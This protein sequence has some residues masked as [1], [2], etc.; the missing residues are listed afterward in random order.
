[1]NLGYI[2]VR[3]FSHYLLRVLQRN[4]TNGWCTQKENYYK[5]L[6]C[7]IMDIGKSRICGV[8]QQ[9]AKS[10]LT[11]QFQPEGLLLNSSLLRGISLF[12]LFS[13]QWTG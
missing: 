4:G 1:M 12:V 5:K 7:V 9:M 2:L 6:T 3:V 8:A 10:E 13:I 11:P